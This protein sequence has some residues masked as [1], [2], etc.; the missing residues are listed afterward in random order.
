MDKNIEELT[1]LLMYLTSWE[2]DGYIENDNHNIEEAKLKKTWKGYSFDAI[3]N[4][5]DKGYLFPENYRNKS[6][7]LTKKGEELATKLIEKYIN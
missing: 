3:N 7:T 6:V 1:L 5:T 4:L 2:E